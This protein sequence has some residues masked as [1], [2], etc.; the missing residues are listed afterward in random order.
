[1]RAD[2][3]DP[4]LHYSATKIDN[5]ITNVFVSGFNVILP[6]GSIAK[7]PAPSQGEEACTK[8]YFR[9]RGAWQRGVLGE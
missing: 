6:D 3:E 8:C 2:A 5:P 7:M 1:M 9:T 4:P